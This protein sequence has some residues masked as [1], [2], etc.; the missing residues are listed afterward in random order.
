[1]VSVRVLFCS[2]EPYTETERG[3][4]YEGNAGTFGESI[5]PSRRTCFWC[6][7]QRRNYIFGNCNSDMD[8]GSGNDPVGKDWIWNHDYTPAC[9]LFGSIGCLWKNKKTAAGSLPHGG[10]HILCFAAFHHR[11]VFWR[12]VQWSRRNG[13]P[14]GRRLRQCRITWLAAGEGNVS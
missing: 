12:A 8:A 11:A 1:M 3:E 2:A 9:I 13:L 4:A 10:G 14:G 5:L 6:M 7:Y